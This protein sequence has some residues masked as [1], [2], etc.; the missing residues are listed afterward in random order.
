MMSLDALQCVDCIRRNEDCP[1]QEQYTKGVNRLN[2]KLIE[3]GHEINWYGSIKCFCDYYM[4]DVN[5]R[6]DECCN[7]GN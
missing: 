7:G 4:K 6:I 5:A 1:W 2:E 3:S